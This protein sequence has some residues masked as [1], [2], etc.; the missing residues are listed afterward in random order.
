MAEALEW[1]KWE[2]SGNFDLEDFSAGRTIINKL[3]LCSKRNPRAIELI[4]AIVGYGLTQLH[5]LAAQRHSKVGAQQLTQVLATAVQEL[6]QFA[7]KSPKQF[8]PTAQWLPSF[9]MP[10]S[11]NKEQQLE[12]DRL[13]VALG[14]GDKHWFKQHRK[15]RKSPSINKTARAKDI[16]RQLIEYLQKYR[17]VCREIAEFADDQPAWTKKLY[18]LPSLSKESWP[19]W[20][21][22]GWEVVL[23]TTG[24][25]PSEAEAYLEIAR[26]T[27]RKNEYDQRVEVTHT[28]IK[29]ALEDAFRQLTTGRSLRG[30]QAS[31]KAK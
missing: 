13:L 11:K 4:A 6:Q 2:E 27:H 16:A 7:L 17:I 12:N 8:Q 20:F 5:A 15:S 22:V 25:E 18:A 21:K 29:E 19:K 9:P 24:G 1:R 28:A 23:E 31:G 26:R 14:V 30:M 10:I 3:L